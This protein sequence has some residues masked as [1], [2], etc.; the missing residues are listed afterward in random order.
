MLRANTIEHR[1]LLCGSKTLSV[2]RPSPQPLS[3]T[4]E[5]GVRVVDFSCTGTD[6][7]LWILDTTW[8]AVILVSDKPH[9]VL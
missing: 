1:L 4:S 5:Y 3:Q 7:G 9:K 2:R 8:Y 6:D